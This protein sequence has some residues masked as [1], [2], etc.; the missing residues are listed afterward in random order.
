M[1]NFLSKIKLFITTHKI[2]S[3]IILIVVIW[4]GYWIHGQLTSTTGEIKYTLSVVGKGTVIASVSGSG[5]VSTSSSIDLKPEV[6]GAVTYVGVNPGDQVYAGET[7]FSLDDIDAQKAVRDA[8]VN[9]QSAQLALDKLQIQ[10]SDENVSADLAKAYGDGFNNVQA[11]QNDLTP[12]LDG[13][14]TILSQQNLSDNSARNSGDTA[15]NYR[16]QVETLYYQAKDALNTNQADFRLLSRASPGSDIENIINETYATT[17]ILSD[18]IKSTKNFVDYLAE[19]TGKA[20]D[21]IATQNTLTNYTNTISTDLANLLA[22]KTSIQN[23]KDLS[24]NNNLDLQSAQLNI[25]QKQNALADAKDNLLKYNILAPFDGVIASVPV[26]VGDSAGSGTTLGTIITSKEVAT[27][28]LNEVDVAKIK[29]GEKTTLTF[30]AIPDLTIAG[31]VAE[32]D[33]IGTVSQG[34]V[35]YNVKI[36]FDTQDIRVKSGMSV[37]A[38]IIT[39]MAQDVVIVPNGAVKNASD[40]TSYVQTFDSSV[41]GVTGSGTFTT[42]LSPKQI[43]IQTGLADDVSTQIVS[44]LKEGDI[45]VTKGA[46]STA[47][48]TTTPSILNAVGGSAASRGGAGGAR[49]FGN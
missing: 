40:G 35:N 8:E 7:L 2:I 33:S 28:V 13:I 20:A 9:L 46:V 12:T 31:Q 16:G 37:T 44:G 10:D 29:L 43:Q 38:T 17:K 42:L 39:D 3:I 25:K 26:S 34:V 36:S 19:D 6:S 11:V 45:V 5:Q 24:P 1:K 21:F 14:N 15:L 30:D 32:I 41:S 18:T 4:A 27:I 22:N 47:A 48:K 49:G 23:S